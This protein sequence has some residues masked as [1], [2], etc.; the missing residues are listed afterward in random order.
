MTEILEVRIKK[1]LV[2]ELDLGGQAKDLGI[3]HVVRLKRDDPR[4]E[5]IR[6]ASEESIKAGNGALYFGWEII[7][8][9]SEKELLE[10]KWFSLY[11]KRHFEPCGEECGSIYDEAKACTCCGAGAV[12]KGAFRF[13]LNRIPKNVDIATTIASENLI[14]EHLVSL[15]KQ[16]QVKGLDLI[17]I[18]HSGRKKFSRNWYLLKTD[19][20]LLKVNERTKVGEDPLKGESQQYHCKHGDTLGIN[21]LSEIYCTNNGCDETD[22]CQTHQYFGIRMGLLRPARHILINQKIRNILIK[23]KIKGYS[24]E[25]AHIEHT[26]NQGTADAKPDK[27]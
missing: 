6:T 19:S 21:L 16:Q 7:R 14:S 10:A 25:V 8:K 3:I 12:L 20:K 15:L 24:L 2:D 17:E 26:S 1:N 13:N 27:K 5:K 18:E 22:I 9:Y 11:S 23:N 4:I